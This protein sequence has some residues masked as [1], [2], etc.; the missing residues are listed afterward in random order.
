VLVYPAS[1]SYPVN[2]HWTSSVNLKKTI[3]CEDMHHNQH[4]GDKNRGIYCH[5]MDSSRSHGPRCL[6]HNTGEMPEMAIDKKKE[7]TP[8]FV[9]RHHSARRNRSHLSKGGN[10]N[11]N[12]MSYMSWS[13]QAFTTA[14]L[15][16]RL[17]FSKGRA[18]HNKHVMMQMPVIYKMF[19][20]NWAW[21]VLG[22]YNKINAML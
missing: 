7:H 22:K 10:N 8:P 5:C 4:T 14:R 16:P 9:L 15:L 6:R 2:R 3:Q 19:G 12:I 18:V 13:T 21:L 17:L 11:N 1:L 20:T